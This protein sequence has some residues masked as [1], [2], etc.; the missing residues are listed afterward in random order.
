MTSGELRQRI[1][2]LID[3]VHGEAFLER[4]HGLL[5]AA[6]AG[7]GNGVWADLSPSERQRVLDSY[8]SAMSGMQLSTT[9]EVMKRRKA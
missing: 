6:Q 1:H 8:R 4:I 5:A 2:A 7:Q 3:Q 9:D